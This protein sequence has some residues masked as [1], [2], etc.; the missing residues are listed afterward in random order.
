MTESQKRNCLI[1]IVKERWGPIQPSSSSSTLSCF[2]IKSFRTFPPPVFSLFVPMF[3]TLQKIY[4]N[5]SPKHLF[6]ILF[7]L[8]VFLTSRCPFPSQ[9]IMSSV[10]SLMHLYSHPSVYW[11]L[12]TIHPSVSKAK[13]SRNVGQLKLQDHLS[14]FCPQGCCTLN[15]DIGWSPISTQSFTVFSRWLQQEGIPSVRG[16]FV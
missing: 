11:F 16:D 9:G 14:L 13:Q 1:I 3:G 6:F 2:H 5:V 12:T 10:N 15:G 4:C 8:T 7:M